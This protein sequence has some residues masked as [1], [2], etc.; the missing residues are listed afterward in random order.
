M[1]KVNTALCKQMIVDY[2]RDNPGHVFEQFCDENATIH[3][4]EAPALDPSNWKRMNK[5]KHWRNHDIT[6][7]GFDCSPYDDQLRAYVHEEDN[8]VTFVEVVGE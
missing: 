6:I 8:R 3:E 1:E 2:L 4:F 5:E 7:R